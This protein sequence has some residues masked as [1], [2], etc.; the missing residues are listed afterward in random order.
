MTHLQLPDFAKTLQGRDLGYLQI[1]AEAWDLEFNAPDFQTGIRSLVPL[2]VNAELLNQGIQALPADARN[3]YYDLVDNE[4]KIPWGLFIRRH[5]I[6]R[7]MGTARRDRERP[8]L[9]PI[10]AVEVLWYRGLI[11]RSFLNTS[12]GLIEYAYIPEDF[13]AITIVSIRAQTLSLG[14]V[15]TPAEQQI[16]IFTSDRI[17]DDACTLLAAERIGVS[18]KQKFIC[19]W[20]LP[21]YAESYLRFLRDLLTQA[22]LLDETAQPIPEKIRAFLE[23]SR[24]QTL[25]N[26][27]KNWQESEVLNELGMIPGLVLEGGMENDV[28]LTRRKILEFIYQAP[29]QNFRVIPDNQLDGDNQGTGIERPFI[30]LTAFVQAVRDTQPDFQRPAGNYDSWLIRER[31]TGL[32]IRGYENWDRIDG[33]FLR[34][35]ITGPLYWLGLVDLA[36][37]EMDVSQVSAFRL[38]ANA[39]DLLQGKSPAGLS[40]ENKSWIVQSDGRIKAGRLSPRKARYQLARFCFSEAYGDDTYQYRI[41]PESLDKAR[42]QG[43]RTNHLVNLLY[44]QSKRIP[45]SLVRALV[46]WEDQGKEAYFE[47]V[48]VLRVKSPEIMQAL[49]T[50]RAAKFLGDPLGPTS[51]IVPPGAVK[52]VMMILAEMDIL[53]ESSI[54]D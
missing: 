36:R 37:K 44:G 38:S 34:F 12:T 5:G 2:L 53:S 39:I 45:P 27:V 43:L 48:I 52:K 10:S 6:F 42:A 33:A 1:I 14:R 35:F 24:G 20:Y 54:E 51:I 46:R 4:G 49:R 11:G 13:L 30:S 18:L 7:E 22:G 19:Q 47:R 3:A 8:F 23:E 25:V 32:F 41:T 31:E 9:K 29:G 16:K 28:H 21:G 15:A 50:S 40:V 26:L 17:V